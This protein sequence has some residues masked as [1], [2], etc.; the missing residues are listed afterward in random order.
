MPKVTFSSAKGIFQEAGTGFQVND[1]PILEESESVVGNAVITVTPDVLDSGDGEAAIDV[2][3]KYFLIATPD[4]KWYVW[5]DGNDADTA[6]PEPLGLDAAS[7]IRI[8]DSPA[9]LDTVEKVCDAITARLNGAVNAGTG[10]DYSIDI[11]TNGICD[12]VLGPA[13]N[14]EPADGVATESDLGA[15]NVK[16]LFKAVD[17]TTDVEITVLPMGSVEG[18]Q[19]SNIVNP[20][21]LINLGVGEDDWTV[22]LSDGTG[23]NGSALQAFG[24]SVVSNAGGETC[25]CTLANATVG[26]KKLVIQ[27]GAGIVAMS[28]SNHAGAAKTATFNADAEALYLLSTGLG[29]GVLKNVGSV[30]IA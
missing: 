25:T 10:I 8:S 4:K 3:G 11:L 23:D 29:W 2:T 18:S 19:G 30:G 12:N 28:Y 7:S 22:T 14:S 20:G 15:D 26:T 16:T 27:S 9:N 24:T 13:D 1:A 6:D 17:N 21:D 5:F